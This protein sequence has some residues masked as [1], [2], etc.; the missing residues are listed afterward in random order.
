MEQAAALGI[1][2][3]RDLGKLFSLMLDNQ[4]ISK[5]LVDKF[6]TPQISTGVD[7]V[8]L[9]PMAKGYGF[10]YERHPKYSV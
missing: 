3:A 9:A 1:G 4:I 8:V 2:T 5:Q 6:R 10:M 7:Y